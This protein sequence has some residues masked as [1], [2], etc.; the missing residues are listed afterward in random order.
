MGVLMMITF[1]NHMNLANSDRSLRCGKSSRQ[2]MFHLLFWSL[3][4]W[5][6]VYII[7]DFVYLSIYQEQG[8]DMISEGLDALKN[9][10]SDMNEVRL[11]ISL[12][13]FST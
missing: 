3:K 11:L 5:W 12:H 4:L 6:C 7:Y 9:M 10:A 13:L 1:K 8:L 2:V